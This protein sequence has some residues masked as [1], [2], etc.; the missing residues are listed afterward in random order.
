MLVS[1]GGKSTRLIVVLP[2][3]HLQILIVVS[4]T[5]NFRKLS[6]K[7]FNNE[8]ASKYFLLEIFVVI[9]KIYA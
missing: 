6:N 5:G 8:A 3:M 2:Y 1:T 7:S 9:N 4:R